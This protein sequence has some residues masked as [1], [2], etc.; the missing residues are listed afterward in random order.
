M[1]IESDG[2]DHCPLVPDLTDLL[3]DDVDQVYGVSVT[4]DLSV[5]FNN[6][7]L[8]ISNRDFNGLVVT[9]GRPVNAD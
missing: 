9:K 4:Q 6:E 2:G 5:L 8:V 3:E 1:V 7:S